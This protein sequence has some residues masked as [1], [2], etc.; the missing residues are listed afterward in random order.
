VS[1]AI[2][3]LSARAC[4]RILRV[5]RTIADLEAGEKIQAKLWPKPSSTASP[6]ARIGSEEK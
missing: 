2:T 4:D 5:S 6:T 3:R 1:P